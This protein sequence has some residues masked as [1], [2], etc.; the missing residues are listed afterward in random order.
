MALFGKKKVAAQSAEE[1]APQAIIAE[2]ERGHAASADDAAVEGEVVKKPI[3]KKVKKAGR[4]LNFFADDTPGERPLENPDLEYRRYQRVT[5]RV[6]I[7]GVILAGL[8][9]VF[10]FGTQILRPS[11]I[12]LARRIGSP[13]GSEKRLIELNL[14]ILTK[15]AILQWSMSTVTEV[16][17]FNFANYNQR[18]SMFH[19]RFHP[20]GWRAFAKALY[21]AKIIDSF[22][23]NQLVA[24]AAPQG[25]AILESEGENQ[26]TFE[27][28]WKVK[29]PVIRKFVTNNDRSEIRKQDVYLTIVR[30]PLTDSPAGM[31][32]KVWFER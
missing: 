23:G 2:A 26:E 14:P 10:M 25:P 17:T 12:Y 31:A 20:E 22:K 1:A 18:I 5:K 19:S 9:F 13:I 30:V 28:E 15:E 29:V 4:G 6:K 11:Y 27:Y 7:Q 32:I 3:K 21:D 24:T 8:I 16:L